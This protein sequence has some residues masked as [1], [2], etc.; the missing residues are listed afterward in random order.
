MLE[1]DY[2]LML[3]KISIFIAVF[4]GLAAVTPLG[5]RTPKTAVLIIASACF[6]AAAR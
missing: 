5:A 3:H 4:T 2:I 1:P 6:A